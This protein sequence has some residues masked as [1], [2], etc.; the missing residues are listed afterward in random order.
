MAGR[1][2]RRR[3]RGPERRVH[4]RRWLHTLH[5]L[6]LWN[7]SYTADGMDEHLAVLLDWAGRWPVSLYGEM[8]DLPLIVTRP[9]EV[10]WFQARVYEGCRCSVNG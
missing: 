5:L 8:V 1:D 7:P 9:H 10:S 6:T 3:L 2:I 4:G